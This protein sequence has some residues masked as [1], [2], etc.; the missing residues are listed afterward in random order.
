[1]HAVFFFIG[2]FF[3]QYD[4]NTFCREYV[5]PESFIILGESVGQRHNAKEPERF[6]EC[7]LVPDHQKIR[8]ANHV[9]ERE[10]R[11][12]VLMIGFSVGNVIGKMGRFYK[13]FPAGF[14]DAVNFL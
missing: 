14:Q 5:G 8:C 4:N 3:P 9:L 13:Y 11:I 10:V 2:L 1:M 7:H 12:E 6:I